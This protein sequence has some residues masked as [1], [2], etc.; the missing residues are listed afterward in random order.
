MCRNIKSLFNLDPPVT[1]H[2][3]QMAALQ[4][5]RKVSGMNAPSQ[6]NQAAFQTAVDAITE[7][8]GTLLNALETRAPVRDRAEEEAKAKARSAQRFARP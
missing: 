6:A 7:A 8:T 2:E 1:E 4:F 3:I 5:V